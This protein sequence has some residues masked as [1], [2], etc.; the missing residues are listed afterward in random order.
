M[1]LRLLSA[2]GKLGLHG[3]IG[4]VREGFAAS[5]DTRLKGPQRPERK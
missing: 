4:K 2:N 5:R 1:A 3:K